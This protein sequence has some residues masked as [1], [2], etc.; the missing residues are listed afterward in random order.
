MGIV[1]AGGRRAA[2]LVG[3]RRTRSKL[4]NV[5]ADMLAAIFQQ[6]NASGQSR[7]QRYASYYRGSVRRDPVACAGRSASSSLRG[8]GMLTNVRSRRWAGVVQRG[9]VRMGS[10]MPARSTVNLAVLSVVLELPGHGYDI[11]TRFVGRF[12][13]LFDSKIPHVYKVL[14]QLEGQELVVA[15]PYPDLSAEGFKP[16]LR[17]PKLFYRAS[18]G[19]AHLCRDWLTGPIPPSAARREVWIRLRATP[20]TD[21]RTILRVLESF[22]KAVV[23]TA[24]RVARDDPPS[25]IDVLALED[26]ETMVEAELRWSASARER[27]LAAAGWS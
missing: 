14:D 16:S 4:E 13:G 19:G 5:L 22:E 17:Q 2:R 20:P 15:S 23:A 6:A 21:Y 25:L 1:A 12:G 7:S 18:S 8:I 11:G 24:G 9:T 27:V 10:G 3:K 26:C